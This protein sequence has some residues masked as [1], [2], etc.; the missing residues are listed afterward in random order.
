MY[1]KTAM[2]IMKSIVMALNFIKCFNAEKKQ[3]K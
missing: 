2:P 1:A 3:H